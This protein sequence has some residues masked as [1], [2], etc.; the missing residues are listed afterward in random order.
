[1]QKGLPVEP[2]TTRIGDL[3]AKQLIRIAW[4]YYME[5]MTQQEI[6]DRLNLSRIKVNRLLQQ[7]RTVGIVEIN[8]RGADGQSI[9][10]ERELCECLNLRDAVVVF[11]KGPEQTLRESL[12]QGAAEWLATRLEPGIR[13]GLSLGRTIAGLPDAFAPLGPVECTFTEI[14]GAASEH[15]GRLQ[16]YNI[17]SRMAE[18]VGGQASYMYAPTVVSNR[19]LYHLLMQESYVAEAMLRARSCDIVLHSVGSLDSEALLYEAG[20]LTAQDLEDLINRGAV[21]DVLG[22]FIDRDGN[23]VASPLDERI[24]TLSLHDLKQIPW[25]VCVAGGPRK[26]DAI[27]GAFN[28]GYFN[29]LITDLET[30][31]ALLRK[32]GCV[33]EEKDDH[34]Q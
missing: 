19:D 33:S 3:E 6:G 9:S 32:T 11:G 10:V 25:S 13:V 29:V 21:G 7:A 22:H 2:R 24:I 27:Y 28:A 12:A 15:T 26:L 23:P 1:V 31:Q 34:D 4:L 8:I 20:H 16:A 14:I 5:G 18:L 17:T 30:A